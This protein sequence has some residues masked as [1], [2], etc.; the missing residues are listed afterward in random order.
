MELLV[1]LL[2][3]ITLPPSAAAMVGISLS[4]AVLFTA[5]MFA[6]SYGMQNPRLQAVAKEELAALLFSVFL[7]LFWMGFD[8]ALNG[9]AS[10]LVGAALGGTDAGTVAGLTSS[11]HQL[12]LASLDAIYQ[13]LKAQYIDLYLFEALIGFLSTI[14]FPL[15]TPIPAVNAVTFTF[16]PFTGLVLL[17]N[18]HTQIVEMISYLI[19]AIW[20]KEFIVIF[21]RDVV[22]LLLLPLGIVMR[23]MPFTRTTGSSLI[24]LSFA[25]YFVLPFAILLSNHLIFDVFKPADFSYTPSKASFFSTSKSDAE[26]FSQLKAGRDESNRIAEQFNGEGSLQVASKAGDCGHNAITRLLC[27]PVNVVKGIWGAVSGFVSTLFSM[28]KFMLGMTGDF[29]FTF[30]NNPAL[31]ASTS[32]GL[33]FFIIREILVLSPFVILV[34]VATVFEIIFTVTLY[35]DIA[36]L[37]GGEAELIGLTKVI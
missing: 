16:A 2:L 29:F 3:Y 34:T 27:S 21:S 9:I 22:P 18:I 15:G 23:A 32:A 26:W 35:R 1:P 28:W 11:H 20:A 5:I 25:L 19:T 33:Y 17:S 7:I 24:A 4:F 31:P 8:V 37:I 6:V 10:G 13:K 14:S 30:F 36:L 12:A